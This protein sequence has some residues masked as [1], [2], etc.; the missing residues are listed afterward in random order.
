MAEVG[1]KQHDAK[2]VVVVIAAID[3]VRNDRRGDGADET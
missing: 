1:V 3:D 2:A